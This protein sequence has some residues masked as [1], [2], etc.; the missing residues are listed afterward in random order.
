MVMMLIIDKQRA[1]RF[2]TIP[3]RLVVVELH[4]SQCMYII[5]FFRA[6]SLNHSINLTVYLTMLRV[7]A[8]LPSK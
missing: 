1:F 5:D 7:L 6:A 8:L 2:I 3:S 4:L